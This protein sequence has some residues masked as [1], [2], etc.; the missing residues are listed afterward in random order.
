MSNTWIQP[1][2]T[3]Y[4][5]TLTPGA[6]TSQFLDIIT[7]PEAKALQILTLIEKN[8]FFNDFLM[9]SALV[10]KGKSKL[11]QQ[12]APDENEAGKLSIQKIFGFLGLA[13]TRNL[14]LSL[15][16]LKKLGK[17]LPRK[18]GE[19]Y[20]PEPGKQ[21]PYALSALEFCE[22]RRMAYTETAF[23]AGFLFDMVSVVFQKHHPEYK[24]INEQLKELWKK[25]LRTASISYG[26]AKCSPK[27]EDNQFAFSGA[28]T[29]EIGRPFM[30]FLFSGAQ[31][32]YSDFLKKAA[33]LHRSL[34]DF[35][36]VFEK[37][38]YNLSYYELSS[39]IVRCF[40]VLQ[41]IE[42]AVYFHREPYFLK[43]S[44]PE[45]LPLAAIYFTAFHLSQVK[46]IEKK[47]VE[48][49]RVWGQAEPLLKPLGLKRQHLDSALKNLA[50]L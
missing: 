27:L 36:T 30:L 4:L 18:D 14:I 8:P 13:G 50:K 43:K 39:I 9:R 28:L 47:P 1:L 38:K 20:N 24:A 35:D 40:P 17:G 33:D 2:L 6:T 37:R 19:E 21:L 48:I 5:P 44:D 16:L 32:P 31:P 46:D 7:H 23:I 26:I 3:K 11:A 45:T 41:K 42:K 34:F 22:N 25:S 15:E 12:E 49:D 29:L 10:V